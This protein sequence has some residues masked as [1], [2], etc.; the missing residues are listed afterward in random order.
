MT[1]TVQKIRIEKAPLS[2]RS[3]DPF[4]EPIMPKP[5]AY[6]GFG[7]MPDRSMSQ[8]RR[9]EI[10]PVRPRGVGDVTWYAVPVDDKGLFNDLISVTS[11]LLAHREGEARADCWEQGFKRG[12]Q[13]GHAAAL[14]EIRKLPW[15]KRMLGRF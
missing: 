11:Q 10:V 2:V 8:L 4:E 15:W 6:C 7:E 14:I 1:Y 12:N 9:Y 5:S 13:A 3:L